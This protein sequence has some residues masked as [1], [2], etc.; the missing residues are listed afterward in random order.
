[1]LP[2]EEQL[3]RL[4]EGHSTLLYLAALAFVGVAILWAATR[5]IGDARELGPAERRKVKEEIVRLMRGE[6]RGLTRAGLSGR[7]GLSVR[8]LRP[9]LDELVED[10]FLV[11]EGEAGDPVYRMRGIDNY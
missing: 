11:T 6:Y 8:D 9:L 1:M 7:I 2:F 5:V 4:A 3:T 10:R